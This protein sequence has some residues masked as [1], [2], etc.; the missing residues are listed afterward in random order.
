MAPGPQIGSHP[1]VALALLCA[2]V[3][4]AACGGDDDPEPA[5]PP[6]GPTSEVPGTTGTPGAADPAA[7]PRFDRLLFEL[8]TGDEE[9]AAAQAR[10]AVEALAGTVDDTELRAAVATVARTGE[11]P[12]ELVD[13]AFAAGA[14]CADE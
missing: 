7:R 13:A 12:Q 4:L 2:C 14:K 1:R 9:L 6:D 11:P 3:G 8:L 5:A 10:C